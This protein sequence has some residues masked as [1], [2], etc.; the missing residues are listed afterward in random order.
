MTTKKYKMQ[1]LDKNSFLHEPHHNN[2][3]QQ[4]HYIGSSDSLCLLWQNVMWRFMFLA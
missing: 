3:K 2:M 1:E 4:M